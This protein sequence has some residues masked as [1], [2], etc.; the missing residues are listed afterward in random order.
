MRGKA[1]NVLYKAG[2]FFTA[3]CLAFLLPYGANATSIS[4]VT[5]KAAPLTKA[6]SALDGM[7]RRLR[8]RPSDV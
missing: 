1:G 7:H 5:V 4:D 2:A 3:L 6:S 8:W